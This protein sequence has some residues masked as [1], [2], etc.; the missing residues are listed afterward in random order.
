VL[1]SLLRDCLDDEEFTAAIGLLDQVVANPAAPA[2]DRKPKMTVDSLTWVMREGLRNET[3][4]HIERTKNR[5][6]AAPA[7]AMD[8]RTETAMKIALDVIPPT[9][10]VVRSV[11][12]YEAARA[13]VRPYVGD[14][15]YAADSADGVY[16]LALEKMGH[17]VREMKHAGVA[18]AMWPILKSNKPAGSRRLATDAKTVSARSQMFPNAN[19]LD[20]GYF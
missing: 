13:E 18:T 10:Q 5:P 9:T 19:R 7:M 4:S 3:K 1:T 14:L 16:K 6:T 15:G 17:D 2:T 8:E 11:Q 20:K 12:R